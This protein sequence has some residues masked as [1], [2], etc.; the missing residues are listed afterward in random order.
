MR[1]AITTVYEN[2]D[3]EWLEWYMARI[4]REDNFVYQ[5]ERIFQQLKDTDQAIVHS[6]DPNGNAKATTTYRVYR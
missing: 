4:R 1:L 3:Q 5:G 2:I 6:N